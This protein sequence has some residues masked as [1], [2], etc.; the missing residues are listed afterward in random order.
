MSMKQQIPDNG[1]DTGAGQM[2][3]KRTEDFNVLV[4]VT[5]AAGTS[6]HKQL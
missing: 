4:N 6:S 5:G 1:Y 2:L 3:P